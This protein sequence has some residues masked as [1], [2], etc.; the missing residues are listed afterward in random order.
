[1]PF[2]TGGPQSA[3]Y[4]IS[5]LTLYQNSE[6]NVFLC[7]T[8][9]KNGVYYEFHLLI[10]RSLAKAWSTSFEMVVVDGSRLNTQMRS[11]QHSLGMYAFKLFAN[12]FVTI[13]VSYKLTMAVCSGTSRLSLA[14]A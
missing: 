10:H 9:V 1:M 14:V 4:M 12:K 11:K 13:R 8:V 7:N 3:C 2:L 6:S 5:S